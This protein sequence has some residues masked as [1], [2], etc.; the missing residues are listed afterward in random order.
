MSR[1][2]SAILF[3]FSSALLV[4]AG[5]GCGDSHLGGYFDG[6]PDVSGGGF[7]LRLEIPTTVTPPP[8]IDP[9]SKLLVPNEALLVGNGPDSCSNQSPPTSDRWCAFSAP[10]SFLGN[11]DLWVI[12]ITRVLSGKTVTCTG[13]D[14]NCLRLTSTLFDGDL[15][16]HGF[17]GD[18]LIYYAENNGNSMNFIGTAYAWRPEWA[19]PRALSSQ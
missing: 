10:S 3:F 7:D 15:T 14:P 17:Q 11:H 6:G 9:G 19:V 18:T 13:S 5:A 4:A 16:M 12:N 2:G 8:P 1:N